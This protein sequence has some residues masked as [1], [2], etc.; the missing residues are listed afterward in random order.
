[1]PKI[2]IDTSFPASRGIELTGRTQYDIKM[3]ETNLYTAY[4]REYSC[5]PEADLF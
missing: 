5:R 2:D 3:L 4:G 1:M